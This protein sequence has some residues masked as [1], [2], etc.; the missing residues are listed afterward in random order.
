M[1]AVLAAAGCIVA[2]CCPVLA[3]VSLASLC[4]A[5]ATP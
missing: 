2:L 3:M 1:S 5:L 4:F